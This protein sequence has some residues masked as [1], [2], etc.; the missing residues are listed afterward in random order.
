VAAV[1]FLAAT[2]ASAQDQATRDKAGAQ[3]A[4]E[5]EKERCLLWFGAI[6]DASVK[7]WVKYYFIGPT[8]YPHP[9]VSISTESF[10]T[11]DYYPEYLIILSEERYD[12]IAAFTRATIAGS[13]CNSKYEV[14][15]IYEHDG[16]TMQHCSLSMRGAPFGVQGREPPACRFLSN[17]LQLP[18]MQWT[19]EERKRIAGL[20]CGGG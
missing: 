8:N 17:M 18:G 4:A 9:I 13:D 5:E 14:I 7:R 20:P 1:A 19:A 12:I 6:P 3:I 16:E 15:V 10:E 11:C 2:A